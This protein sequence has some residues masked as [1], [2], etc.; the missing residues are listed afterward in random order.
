MLRIETHSAC[1]NNSNLSKHRT[2]VVVRHS[3]GKQ[4]PLKATHNV[5]RFKTSVCGGLGIYN[6]DMIAAVIAMLVQGQKRSQMVFLLLFGKVK[7]WKDIHLQ[8]WNFLTFDVIFFCHLDIGAIF[9][10]RFRP[11]ILSFMFRFMFANICFEKNQNSKIHI[12]FIINITWNETWNNPVLT[13]A[14]LLC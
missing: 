7:M 4:R 8:M 6:F 2:I 3:Q 13:F 10:R 1:P 14:S 12:M 9:L 11:Y 5:C